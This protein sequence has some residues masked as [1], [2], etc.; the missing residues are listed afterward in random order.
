MLFF[1]ILYSVKNPE[2]YHGFQK[3]KKKKM[4]LKPQIKIMWLKTGVMAD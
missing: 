2:K 1:W 3:K 4:F